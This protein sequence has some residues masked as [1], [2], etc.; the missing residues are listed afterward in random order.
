MHEWHPT[1]TSASILHDL[2]ANRLERPG[3]LFG[4]ESAD[5][6]GRVLERGVIWFD[7]YA[8]HYTSDM[9]VDPAPPELVPERLCDHVPDRALR[10]GHNEVQRRHMQLGGRQLVPAQDKADLWAVSVCDNQVP[11][12]CHYL[13]YVAARLL[14]GHPL[15]GYIL[16]PSVCNERVPPDGNNGRSNLLHRS[17]PH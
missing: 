10:I 3:L 12:P 6:L 14:T 2:P 17:P 15:R 7:Q 16:M 4:D 5:P 11:A 1:P 9:S 8:G 13:S